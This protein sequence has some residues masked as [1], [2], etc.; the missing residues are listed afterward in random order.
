[1]KPEKSLKIACVAFLL[2]TIAA[3]VCAID[4]GMELQRVRAEKD[5]LPTI[6][7]IQTKVGVEPDGII[8]PKT[9][10][11]WE[12]EINNQYALDVWPERKD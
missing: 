8:G 2:F 1:M 11:A 10:C 3:V 4:T 7:E 5:R 9:I 12:R 6:E